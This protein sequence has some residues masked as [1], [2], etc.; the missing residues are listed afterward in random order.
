MKSLLVVCLLA[1]V[2]MVSTAPQVPIP[3]YPF[4][5][6]TISNDN[7]KSKPIAPTVP[8]TG[9]IHAE[10]KPKE[11]LSS[12]P[13]VADRSRC[14]ADYRSKNP[15]VPPPSSVEI[16]S[17]HQYPFVVSILYFSEDKGYSYECSGSLISPTKVLTESHCLYYNPTYG[18]TLPVERLKVRL[19]KHFL[20]GTTSDAQVTRNVTKIET[21]RGSSELAIVTMDS[22]VEYT[23]TISPVCLVPDCFDDDSGQSVIAMGWNY[24]PHPHEIETIHPISLGFMRLSTL[25][26]GKCYD[27][28]VKELFQT[29][30]L[31]AQKTCGDLCPT[32]RGGPVVIENKSQDDKSCRF[33]QV[34]VLNS[35]YG[36][37]DVG[38]LSRVKNFLP[39]FEEN[40]K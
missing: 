38:S 28:D 25:P 40:S 22:P 31:C 30:A 4:P 16:A 27:E 15:D 11:W 26:I 24:P 21:H 1:L 5:G 12:T 13:T 10:S 39:W 2:V 37:S 7:S 20:N 34:A 23:D 18:I 9:V 17:P 29:E 36:H 6:I 35:Y 14:L 8:V 32:Y 19:G 3:F 33:M